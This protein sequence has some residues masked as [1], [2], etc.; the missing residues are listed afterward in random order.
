[1]PI[2]AI[3]G[4]WVSIK[5]ESQAYW[6]LQFKNQ[7]IVIDGEELLELQELIAVIKEV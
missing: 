1:M 3:I 5:Q 4:R 2:R 7:D 6:T